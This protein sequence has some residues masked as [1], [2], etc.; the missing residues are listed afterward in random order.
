VKALAISTALAA[1]FVCGLLFAGTA[2]AEHETRSIVLQDDGLDYRL[3]ALTLVGA[4]SM[5]V[6]FAVL[7]LRWEA[8]DKEEERERGRKGP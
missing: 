5:L 6:G 8:R 2:H 1:V 7:V 3:V 4:V